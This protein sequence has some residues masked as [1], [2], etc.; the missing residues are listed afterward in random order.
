[1][2]SL[3]HREKD[4]LDETYTL[5]SDWLQAYAPF[6]GNAL[7]V[8]VTESGRWLSEAATNVAKKQTNWGSWVIGGIAE[9]PELLSLLLSSMLCK[10]KQKWKPL[11]ELRRPGA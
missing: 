11:D 7:P 4:A 9:R 8:T 5:W 6:E 1:M 3:G 10:E 2:Y